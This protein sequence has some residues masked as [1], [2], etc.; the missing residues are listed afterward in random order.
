MGRL[1]GKKDFEY[2]IACRRS[3]SEKNLRNY[4]LQHPY[5]S[6]VTLA[7]IWLPH[8]PAWMC[9]ISRIFT[10]VLSKLSHNFQTPEN[11]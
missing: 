11:E 2:M 7:P 1:I 6:F 8:W 3:W 9:T 5:L 10:A 4:T